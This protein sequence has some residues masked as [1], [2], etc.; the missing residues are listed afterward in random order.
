M[1]RRTFLK[2]STLAAAT[3]VVPGALSRGAP[4]AA[5][6]TAAREGLQE[7]RRLI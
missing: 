3:V 1:I 7:W 6:V 2:R 5:G 4:G